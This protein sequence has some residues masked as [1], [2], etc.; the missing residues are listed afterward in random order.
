MTDPDLER[1]ITAQDAVLVEVN[2]ELL[3]GHKRSHWMW[4]MFPQLAGLGH[5]MT[6]QHYA[7][8]GLDQARRYLAD[9]V[10]GNRLRQHVRLILQ[11]KTRT[12]RDILDTPD[13]LKFRSCLT[14]FKAVSSTSDDELL[15]QEGLRQFYGGEADPQTIRLLEEIQ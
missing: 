14:L 12:A 4:F 9:P 11:H 13:D 5:S 2:A 15:F 3:A 10:L 8:I 1:F 7:I 6:A